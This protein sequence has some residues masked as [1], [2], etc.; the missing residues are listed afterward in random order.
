MNLKVKFRAQEIQKRR[1]VKMGSR[2][3]GLGE[4][5]I[6]KRERIGPETKREHY[7]KP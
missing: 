7:S 2:E 3:D 4:K 1:S 5:W 6:E